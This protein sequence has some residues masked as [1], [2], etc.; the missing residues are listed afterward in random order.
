[1]VGRYARRAADA[2]A[3]LSIIVQRRQDMQS[4]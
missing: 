2:I 4:R 3:T 1:L